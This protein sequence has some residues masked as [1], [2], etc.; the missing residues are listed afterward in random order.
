MRRALDGSRD[1]DVPRASRPSSRPRHARRI[2]LN[3][4]VRGR[5]ATVEPERGGCRFAGTVSSRK[6]QNRAYHSHPWSLSISTPLKSKRTDVPWAFSPH[7]GVLHDRM[8]AHMRTILVT[9][10]QHAR[11]PDCGHAQSTHTTDAPRLWLSAPRSTV[12]RHHRWR[13][14]R[15]MERVS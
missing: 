7:I 12:Y 11:R 8:R 13:A 15:I 14:C 9:Q 4:Y 2:F 3:S 1:V 10:Q 5:G 6:N